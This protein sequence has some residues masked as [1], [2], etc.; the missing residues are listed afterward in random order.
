MARSALDKLLKPAGAR[1]CWLSPGGSEHADRVRPAPTIG[2]AFGADDADDADEEGVLPPLIYR[3]DG[4]VTKKGSIAVVKIESKSR[5]R[6]N[7]V[8]PDLDLAIAIRDC[9]LELKDQR[10]TLNAIKDDLRQWEGLKLK[11]ENGTVSVGKSKLPEYGVLPKVDVNLWENALTDD[12]RKA[13]IRAGFVLMKY[14]RE[15]GT[16]LTTKTA[17]AKSHDLD[18]A[19]N[20]GGRAIMGATIKGSTVRGEACRYDVYES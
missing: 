16:R 19:R 13:V 3:Q 20:N 17:S 12:M 10:E 6:D 18:A 15:E 7:E 8:P 14:A 9:S 5:E 11:L 2:Q 4:C 1:A